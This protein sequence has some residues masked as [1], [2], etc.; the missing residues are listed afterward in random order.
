MD[1]LT[2]ELQLVVD[3]LY[4][5]CPYYGSR[6]VMFHLRREGYAVGRAKARS[7]MSAVGWR[8]VHPGPR[9]TKA[10]PGH[11]I[12][13]YLLRGLGAILPGEVICADITYIPVRGGFFYLVAIMDWAS[14]FVL[15]WELDNTMEVGF[16]VSAVEEALRLYGA[17]LISNT[18]Q[19]SQF[20]SDAFT[21]PLLDAGVRISMD[22]KGRWMDNRFIERLWRSLKY[23]A[24]YLEELCGGQHARRVI[25]AWLDHYNH[26]RPH[27]AFAGKTPPKYTSPGGR[28]TYRSPPADLPRFAVPC[29]P[30]ATRQRA[31]GGTNPCRWLTISSMMPVRARVKKLLDNSVVCCRA[32]E[33]T[34]TFA[35][36]WALNNISRSPKV[37]QNSAHSGGCGNVP[38]PDTLSALKPDI[39]ICS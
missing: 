39:S 36:S 2:L 27:L 18:D 13:P 23:E 28:F 22:G 35:H 14:R 19:G 34:T 32:P 7:L 3:K 21:R 10:Q 17:P 11:K 29:A 9:T 26:R 20:T 25:G 15:S 4:M 24:V 5:E 30:V 16:C 1:A 38:K 31:T 33:L 6:R 12:Y 37:V 8:T